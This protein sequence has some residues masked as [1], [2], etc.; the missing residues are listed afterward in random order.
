VILL[1]LVQR[2]TLRR[3]ARTLPGYAG[4]TSALARRYA[5]VSTTVPQYQMRKAHSTTPVR[6]RRKWILEAPR[7][8]GQGRDRTMRLSRRVRI[9]SS[10]LLASVES[11]DAQGGW[12][13]WRHFLPKDNPEDNEPRLLHAEPET[14]TKEQC[15]A[16][17]KEYRALDP[18]KL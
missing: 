8:E 12:V 3:G 2:R 10:C 5:A 18:E 17:A 16:E 15:E 1:A 7:L 14:T 4:H 11:A 6:I 13:L 9:L